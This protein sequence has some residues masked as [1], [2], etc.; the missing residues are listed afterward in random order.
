MWTN[1]NREQLP[2]FEF[3]PHYLN[4]KIFCGPATP[5]KLG[6]Q[7]ERIDST[8]PAIFAVIRY[9]TQKWHTS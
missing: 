3:A 6:V 9:L 2:K 8:T 5:A 7:N 1:E 4:A